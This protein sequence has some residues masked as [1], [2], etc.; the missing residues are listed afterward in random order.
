[1]KGEAQGVIKGCTDMFACGQ[2]P[3]NHMTNS[4]FALS[5]HYDSGGMGPGQLSVLKVMKL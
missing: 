4:P 5:A 1:M 2:G 3:I